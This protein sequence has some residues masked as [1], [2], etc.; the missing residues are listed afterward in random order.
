MELVATALGL[1][2]RLLTRLARR[3][4]LAARK[5]EGSRL[6][7]LRPKTVVEYFDV[8]LTDF[9]TRYWEA[10]KKARAEKR[11]SK[12]VNVKARKGAGS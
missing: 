9:E 5:F 8:S 6:W 7:W 2:P 10:E 11:K 1:D 3:G 4:R 12:L